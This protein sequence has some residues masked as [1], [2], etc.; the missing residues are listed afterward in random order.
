MAT[1]RTGLTGMATHRS[2]ATFHNLLRSSRPLATLSRVISG[3]ASTPPVLR[4]NEMFRFL[5][6][7]NIP[8][9][10]RNPPHTPVS[11]RDTEENMRKAMIKGICGLNVLRL[12]IALRH[13]SGGNVSLEMF[14][15]PGSDG[16]DV[17]RLLHYLR[18]HDVG[19]LSALS[20]CDALEHF[21]DLPVVVG[22]WRGRH[23]LDFSRSAKTAA[24]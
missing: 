7:S 5:R 4:P 2:S 16:E 24:I 17:R 9:P 18:Q 3:P 10:V 20:L 19:D 6:Q 14:Q 21:G 1:D 11:I 8:R 12:V 23:W 15:L 22:D 13:R